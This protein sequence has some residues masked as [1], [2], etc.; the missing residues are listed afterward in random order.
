MPLS[1]RTS[2]KKTLVLAVD[3]L[4]TSSTSVATAP[5]AEI[6]P[7]KHPRTGRRAPFM[8]YGGHLFEMQFLS[9]PTGDELK[10]GPASWFVGD[11]VVSDGRLGLVTPIDPLFLALPFLTTNGTRYSP[12]DQIFPMPTKEAPNTQLLAKQEGMAIQLGHLCDVNDKHG[13]DMIFFRYNEAKTLSWIEKKIQ[14]VV[15]LI[16][17]NPSLGSTTRNDG[18]QFS[19]IGIL[20]GSN[21]ASQSN[22]SGG[23]GGVHTVHW[24]LATSIISEYLNLELVNKVRQKLASDGKLSSVLEKRTIVSPTKKRKS[25]EISSNTYN[26][27]QSSSSS[28]SSS[29]SAAAATSTSTKASTS[30][31][32]S[33]SSSNTLT[34]KEELEALMYGTA[35]GNNAAGKTAQKPKKKA[36]VAMKPVP[37]GQKSVM[38]FFSMSGK[39]KK[40][41]P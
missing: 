29:S 18:P 16:Q 8:L 19:K 38:S 26:S 22:S 35:G 41:K 31:S 24:E 2:L 7:F 11:S 34:A 9:R 1:S 14:N 3:T 36:K 17:T 27:S 23:S 30:M 10:D 6:L 39:K 20:V 28:S 37:R 4:H 12:L 32:S 5:P 40:K 13:P 25:T 21:A 15:T 33:S